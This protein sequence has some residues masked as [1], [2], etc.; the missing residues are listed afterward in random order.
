MYAI[1]LLNKQQNASKYS[2]L[3]KWS[4]TTLKTHIT[5]TFSQARRSGIHLYLP[6]PL[7]FSC[8]EH[9]FFLCYIQ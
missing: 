7:S 5:S 3:L 9:H 1:F 8:S 2:V 4:W 6:M